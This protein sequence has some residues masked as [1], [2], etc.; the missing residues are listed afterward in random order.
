LAREIVQ[1]K[2]E[3]DTLVSLVDYEAHTYKVT[4]I[5][6]CKLDIKICSKLLLQLSTEN[7]EIFA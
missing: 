7:L 2:Q 1:G 5:N 3:R 4:I 6:Q